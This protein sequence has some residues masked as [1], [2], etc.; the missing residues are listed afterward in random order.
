VLVT[1]GD[2]GEYC[3]YLAEDAQ[4]YCRSPSWTILQTPLQHGRAFASVLDDVKAT[5]LYVEPLMLEYDAI[6]TFLLSP[7]S[8]GWRVVTTGDT[9]DGPWSVLVRR[10]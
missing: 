1:S 6:K 2:G 4:H 8:S 7:G 3:R 10:A 5:A 9:P